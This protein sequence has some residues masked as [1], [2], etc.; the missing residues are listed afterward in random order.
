MTN[1]LRALFSRLRSMFQKQRLDDDFN[2]EL[3][4]H[5]EMLAAENEK[6]GLTPEEARRAAILRVGNRESLRETH[7]ETRGMRL[8][9]NLFYDLRYTLRS[10]RH[11]PSF[12]AISL[13]ILALA[14]GANIAVFSV[15]NNLLLRPLPF[16]NSQQLVWIAPPPS[17]CGFSCATYSADAYEEFRAQ[18]RV[19]QDVTGYMAFSTADNQRLTGRGE[20]EPA[21]SIE[22][23]GNFFDV[24]GVQPL[25]GRTFTQE[26]SRGD[27]PVVVLTNSFWRR[28]FAAD[29][30]IV[31]KSIDLS[32]S[33]VTI[34]GVLPPSFDFGAVFSPGAK[35][36]LFT[37]LDLDRERDWGNIVTLIGRLKPGVTLPQAL[38]DGKRVAP[39]L[40]FNVKY[41][42]SLGNYKDSLIPTSLK[43]YVIGKLRRS[44]IALWSAVAAILL[45]A[46]VNL[47]NLLLARTAARAKELA[48]RGALG[49][50]RARIVGQLL[51]ESLLL[52]A[53]GALLG[54]AWAAILLAWL[55]QK[56]SLALPLLG[57]VRIDLQALEWTVLVAVFTALIFGLLPGLRVTSGNLQEAL[58]DSGPGAGL[59]RKHETVRAVLVVA[60]VG[61]ACVLLVTAGLLLRSFVKVVQ[62]DLGFR[63]EGAASI[64]IDYD[65]SAP[66]PEA[67]LAKR[68]AIFQQILERVA[69]LPGV[70]AVGM[71]DYLPLGPNREWDAPVPE[72]KVF[73][74]HELPNPLVYVITPG[75]IRAMGIRVRGREFTWQD[76]PR[77]ERVVL[78]NASAARIY[79]PNEDPVNK[80][81]L[82]NNGQE[83]V[84]VV[85]VVDDVHEENVEGGPGAQIYYPVTQQE[86]EGEQLVVR[87]AL[88]PEILGGTVLGALR[89]LNPNQPAAQFR[90]IR[91]LV[92][93]AVSPRRFFMLLVTAFAALGLLLATLGIYGVISY[94]V[95][96]RT[97]EI[98]I[99][100]ALGASAGRVQNM[101]LTRTLRL[102][103]I[104]VLVGIVLSL[105]LSGVIA[106]LL[107][108]TSPW[109]LS[110]YTGMALT[111]LLVAALAGYIPARRASRVEPI[112]AL[113]TSQ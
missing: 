39:N 31:G 109:D 35:V 21:T 3:A 61:L 10:L 90:P 48:L 27:H 105:V 62:V 75:F 69:A 11:D 84:R 33:L 24:L 102:A 108:A 103:S 97:S 2:E 71:S 37:P 74:P 34:V 87:S 58:K 17:A 91:M 54:L 18:S 50:S 70:Q 32:G 6:S 93:R 8:L 29:P 83:H 72:G 22:L 43:D 30:A 86:P 89:E 25:M 88:P 36:D 52:S 73:A 38:D 78:I 106:S 41:P 66:T 101:V 60:E 15:V 20:S 26:E 76:G 57:T 4:S 63:P 55:R 51:L 16:P 19:Y 56:A 40:Y 96:Q 67:G 23:I 98:G 100:M 79:W 85:G 9:E 42:Q 65:D 47:S 14:I 111:L 99:R 64:K 80:I 53:T 77:G 92:D 104:G 28:H 5:I 59:G 49:A 112:K 113:R 45:I 95:E 46:A 13:I 82:R 1:A 94:S 7:R 110:A 68:I 12:T 107:F 44:L 81:L